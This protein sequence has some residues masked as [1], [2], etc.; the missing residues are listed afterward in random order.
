[1]NPSNLNMKNLG[2]RLYT[3]I[4][5]SMEIKMPSSRYVRFQ[6]VVMQRTGAMVKCANVGKISLGFLIWFEQPPTEGLIK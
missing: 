2:S 5:V 6:L 4:V 3:P 1:M